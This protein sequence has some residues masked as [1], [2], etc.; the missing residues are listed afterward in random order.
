MD[1]CNHHLIIFF[2][3]CKK[4]VPDTIEH[5]DISLNQFYG[6]AEYFKSRHTHKDKKLVIS[7]ME[8]VRV[9]RNTC[10]CTH[11]IYVRHYMHISEM[12][13]VYFD[14]DFCQPTPIPDLICRY[15]TN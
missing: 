2:G 4:I 1:L 10:I 12:V 11:N 3:F 9:Q 15:D 14:F 5:C 13:R 8:S 7:S 6:S